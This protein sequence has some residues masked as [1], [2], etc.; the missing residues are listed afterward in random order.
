MAFW[1]SLAYK[2]ITV[3]FTGTTVQ[4]KVIGFKVSR[5][6]ARMVQNATSI[7]NFVS[8]RS[9]FFGFTTAKG[10]TIKT[11][12]NAPQIFVLFNYA[13]G[14][15]IKIAYPNNEPEKAVIVNWKEFPGILLMLA[16]GVLLLFVGKDYLFKKKVNQ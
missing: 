10:D 4:A 11:Y 5:N 1:G 16:F 9:P 14:D 15:E 12:S 2:I 8:G 7:K 6:G 3:P 13:I